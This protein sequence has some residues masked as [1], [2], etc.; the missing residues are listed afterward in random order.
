[1][2]T[3]IILIALLIFSAFFSGTETALTGLSR[4]K[5]R[6][7]AAQ[8]SDVGSLFS[9]WIH[10]PAKLLSTILIGNN[11][12]NITFTV[13]VT[14]VAIDFA[15]LLPLGK[16]IVVGITTV[17]VAVVIIVFGEIVPKSFAYQH[18]ERVLGVVGKPLKMITYILFPVTGFLS[19]ITDKMHTMLGLT[20]KRAVQNLTKQELRM[21]IN[22]GVREKILHED[23]RQILERIL[24]FGDTTV[25][26]VMVH[27]EDIDAVDL[28]KSMDHILDFIVE[29]GH[30]R[31]PVY[32]SHLDNIKGVIYVR[33][34]LSVWKDD[35]NIVLNEFIRTPYYVNNDK[36]ISALLHEFRKGQLH[37][38]IV[39][40]EDRTVR[41]IVTI[42][43]IIDEIMGEI[44]DEYDLEAA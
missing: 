23:E 33:D 43:D 37:M 22:L 12:V 2:N 28:S 36:K 1:M 25:S 7:L 11:I 20:H 5:M 26:D 16:D 41:G 6:K 40:D 9:E 3:F 42:E 8:K 31:I 24:K 18:T 32:Q 15:V 34:M 30:S 13:I 10:N 19:Y 21:L 17:M 39:V 44:L 27:R 14:S 29:T 4:F 35:R 38:A